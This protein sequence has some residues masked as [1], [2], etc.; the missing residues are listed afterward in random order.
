MSANLQRLIAHYVVFFLWLSRLWGKI[1]DAVITYSALL[2]Y[3]GIF[4]WTLQSAV[5]KRPL[6]LTT[7]PFTSL[8]Y[9]QKKSQSSPI[10]VMYRVIFG[11]SLF[12]TPLTFIVTSIYAISCD[13]NLWCILRVLWIMLVIC[14]LSRHTTD[15]PKYHHTLQVYGLILLFSWGCKFMD[16]VSIMSD[17]L[18]D[19]L[20]EIRWLLRI[21]MQS[22]HL[23]SSTECTIKSGCQFYRWK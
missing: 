14:W 22:R 12:D 3:F 6:N 2:M 5:Q 13:I 1:S 15:C 7:H 16:G 8:K 23:I 4:I 19:F 20:Q 11:S 21:M 9:S 18:P 17:L 10:R